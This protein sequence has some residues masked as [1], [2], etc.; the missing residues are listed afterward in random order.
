M[1]QGTTRST[2]SVT[3]L[4]PA[5]NPAR[6][7]NAIITPYYAGESP[8]LPPGTEPP[9]LVPTHPIALPGD[10]WFGGDLKPTHP[11]ALPGDPWWPKPP[12][13]N[14][15]PAG[16]LALVRPVPA[17]VTAPTEPAPDAKWMQVIMEKGSPPTFALVNPYV[18]TSPSKG[19]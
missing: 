9:P 4:D 19:K 1:G 18:S 3:E 14:E 13:P 11:I 12:E 17:D 10:P 5:G 16:K 8:G 6:S 15:P 7:Y 2:Y